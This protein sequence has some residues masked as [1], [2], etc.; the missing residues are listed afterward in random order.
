MSANI[1]HEQG[2]V[3]PSA[4][5]VRKAEEKQRLAE[6][7]AAREQAAL[8]QLQATASKKSPAAVN[9]PK[10]SDAVVVDPETPVVQDTRW[11][12]SLKP[13]DLKAQLKLRNLSTQ[14]SKKELL[15]RLLDNL[16]C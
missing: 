13:N 4:S 15:A 1:G 3:K 11:A 16:G 2:E 9:T 5:A 10:N 12:K 6:I 14:G 7:T 8:E